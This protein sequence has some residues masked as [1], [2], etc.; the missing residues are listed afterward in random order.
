[1]MTRNKPSGKKIVNKVQEW[2]DRKG[3]DK[4][5]F[6]SKC[7]GAKVEIDGRKLSYDTIS[8]I[9]DGETNINMITATLITLALGLD[10]ISELFDIE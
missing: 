8:R 7:I 5:D 2:C 6:I 9:Y 3:M 1:M 10:S 4:L